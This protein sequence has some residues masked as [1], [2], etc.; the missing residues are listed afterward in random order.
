MS[1]GVEPIASVGTKFDPELHEAVDM[2]LVDP[3]DDGMIIEEYSSG[4][5][6]GNRLL[7]PA[8]VKVGKAMAQ[9]AGE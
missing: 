8:R 4:Y 5:K 7:R 3:E 1:V 6:F 9:S 2:T